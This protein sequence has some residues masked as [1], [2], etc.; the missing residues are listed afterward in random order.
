MAEELTRNLNLIKRK[1][2]LLRNHFTVKLLRANLLT[3]K[4][5]AKNLLT[6]EKSHI[7]EAKI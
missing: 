7:K 3:K 1:R 5:M 2:N 6:E 4:I